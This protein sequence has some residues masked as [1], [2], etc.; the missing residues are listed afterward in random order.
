[1]LD[2]SRVEVGGDDV[3]LGEDVAD[4]PG[5]AGPREFG[6]AVFDEVGCAPGALA[7]PLAAVP[8]CCV[9]HQ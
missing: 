9:L 6:D 2:G 3:E 8:A 7:C 4:A 1:M 5:A